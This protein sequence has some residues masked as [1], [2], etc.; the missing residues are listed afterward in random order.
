MKK[1]QTNYKLTENVQMVV[2]EE[3]TEHICLIEYGENCSG[4]LKHWG[5]KSEIISELKEII[6]Q[7]E[8]FN[9]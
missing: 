7:L 3:F 4:I 8:K 1:I 5:S 6:S 9:N 2:N